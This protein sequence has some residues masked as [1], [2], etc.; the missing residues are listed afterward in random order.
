MKVSI[1]DWI[2][3]S[4]NRDPSRWTKWDNVLAFRWLWYENNGK[5]FAHDSELCLDTFDRA[6]VHLGDWLNYLAR[7]RKDDHWNYKLKLVERA[8]EDY[9]SAQPHLR[10]GA[11]FRFGKAIAA[12]CAKNDDNNPLL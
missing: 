3:K 10:D 2:H 12:V 8:L 6:V 9:Q 11:Q 1:F 7:H 5:T 4:C